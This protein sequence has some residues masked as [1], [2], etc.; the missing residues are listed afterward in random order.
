MTVDI[1]LIDSYLDDDIDTLLSLLGNEL[2]YISDAAF[3]RSVIRQIDIAKIWLKAN[4]DAFRKRI[5]SSHKVRSLLKDN[6]INLAVV[7]IMDLISD[8]CIGVSPI[9]VAV[10]IVKIGIDKLCYNKGDIL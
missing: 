2:D 9:T 8:I 5:C 7:A 1:K 6:Y 4:S 10:L 3:R